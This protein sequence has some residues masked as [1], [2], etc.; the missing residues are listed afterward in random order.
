[1]LTGAGFQALANPLG[2]YSILHRG[3][4]HEVVDPLVVKRFLYTLP[5]TPT[6]TH[7]RTDGHKGDFIL[8]PILCIALHWTDNKH[9]SDLTLL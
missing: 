9:H 1:M 8:C 2:D 5:H 4:R 7:A 3:Q 6:R